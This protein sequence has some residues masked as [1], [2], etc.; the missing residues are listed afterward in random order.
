[1]TYI[2]DRNYRWVIVAAAFLITFITN[3]L[4]FCSGVFMLPIVN[5]MGWS[6]GLVSSNMLVTGVAYAATLLATSFLTQRYGYKW[7]LGISMAL[8]GI[9]LLLS[10]L[11]HELWQLYVF[12]GLFIG[13]SIA[14][15]FAIPVALVALWFTKRQGLALGLATL[16]VSM[17]TAF[18]PLVISTLI[19]GFGWRIAMVIAGIVV[20][21]VCIPSVFLI[22]QPPLLWRQDEKQD[23]DNNSAADDE[24][25]G[26][27]LSQAVPT[28]QF[29]MLFIILLIFLSNLSLTA[30]H[31]VPYAVDA[32]IST[33]QAATLLTLVGIFGIAGR[34]LSGIASDKYG[35]KPVML[36]GLV[37]LT[38]ITL[39]IALRQEQWPFYLFA[40]LFG[41]AYS[42]VATMMV[43]MTRYVFGT[44]A[45]GPI[46]NIMMVA[47][48]IGVAIGP[49][50]AGYIFDISGGYYITFIAATIALAIACL[51]TAIIK[52]ATAKQRP[53]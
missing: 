49:W 33:V 4:F 19:Q 30:Q 52:P 32:G 50:M 44:K 35:V 18:V 28:G 47:D 38:L 10:S 29:Y 46:F 17:G 31:L 9:G 1:M 23:G 48:G 40:A 26:L 12:N 13:L 6:R 36:C 37:I 43:R 21:A 51:L 39:M 27:T 11:I 24:L 42:G 7:V 41:L 8:L 14:A 25:V 45:L 20:I 15:S 53:A 5:E 16:G 2:K 22:R 3:G 34:L